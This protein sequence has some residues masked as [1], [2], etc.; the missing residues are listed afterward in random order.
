MF[1]KTL[2]VGLL[3]VLCC[4][5]AEYLAVS[6]P[7]ARSPEQIESE[8]WNVITP[9]VSPT[10]CHESPCRSILYRVTSRR[11]WSL[12]KRQI[13]SRMT[14]SDDASCHVTSTG[15][16]SLLTYHVRSRLK[17]SII[18]FPTAMHPDS[19]NWP[20]PGNSVF[21]V[22]RQIASDCC[23]HV[24]DDELAQ[25]CQ[26]DVDFASDIAAAQRKTH[27]KEDNV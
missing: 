5:D 1:A 6:C 23:D 12:A 3:L 20:L 26:N 11:V 9:C 4:Y 18:I 14:D 8:S 25:N 10:S 22:K 17:S 19:S 7:V 16:T 21:R 2:N 15:N 27:P 24:G 13:C